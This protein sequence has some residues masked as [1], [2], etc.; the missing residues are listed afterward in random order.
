MSAPVIV[1]PFATD[2]TKV[3][4]DTVGFL[5]IAPNAR[6]EPWFLISPDL[7][8]IYAVRGQ[9]A[10]IISEVT[11]PPVILATAIKE[12]ANGEDIVN[13]TAQAFA[14]EILNGRVRDTGT[15]FRLENTSSGGSRV[16]IPSKNSI[17]G[18]FSGAAVLSVEEAKIITAGTNITRLWF[19]AGASAEP[20]NAATTND[21][22]IDI[23]ASGAG[24]PIIEMFYR[25]LGGGLVLLAQT[26]SYPIAETASLQ[27]ERT[28]SLFVFTVS[29]PSLGVVSA[30]VSRSLVRNDGSDFFANVHRESGINETDELEVNMIK[31]YPVS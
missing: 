15:K 18:E 31:G 30:N 14:R 7:K 27:I 22:S 11:A 6:G 17:S 16:E 29:T 26:S 1:N 25:N 13:H 3:I 23:F 21:A 19:A 9:F 10:T 24:N 8:T 28:D 20:R 4:V 12:Y 2:P 5:K